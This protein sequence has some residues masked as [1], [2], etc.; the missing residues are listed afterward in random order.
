MRNRPSVTNPDPA[1]R[2]PESAKYLGLSVKTVRRHIKAGRLKAVRLGM[3][4]LGIRVSEL[5]RFLNGGG[6]N[7]DPNLPPLAYRTGFAKHQHNRHN[8]KRRQ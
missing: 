3:L 5:E 2:L 6:N 1:L 7:E 8:A 4:A